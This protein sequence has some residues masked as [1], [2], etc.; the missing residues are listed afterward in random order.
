MSKNKPNGFFKFQNVQVVRKPNAVRQ[1]HQN[2]QINTMQGTA[3]EQFAT[4]E[5]AA[6]TE[7]LNVIDDLLTDD[8]S[9]D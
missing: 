3:E 9:V 2:T 4:I 5:A 7:A 6:R 8:E 1:T